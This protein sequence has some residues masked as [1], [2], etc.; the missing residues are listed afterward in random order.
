MFKDLGHEATQS[1]TLPNLEKCFSCVRQSGKLVDVLYERREVQ[2]TDDIFQLNRTDRRTVS[3]IIWYYGVPHPL[4]D[5]SPHP[6]E[7]VLGL[8][9]A[10]L[11]DKK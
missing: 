2:V 4:L 11:P 5:F 10:Q 6:E 1:F 3:N 9:L 8:G 7:G